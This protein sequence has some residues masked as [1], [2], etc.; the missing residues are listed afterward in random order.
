MGMK[1]KLVRHG[2][3]LALILDK[4]ILEL[5]DIDADSDI[6]LHTYGRYLLLSEVSN[7]DEISE[8]E[9]REA[10]EWVMKHHGDT[11]RKLAD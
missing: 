8:V 3:S 11:L 10:L 1:K 7:D 6:E 2:N 5:L 4:P 9:A